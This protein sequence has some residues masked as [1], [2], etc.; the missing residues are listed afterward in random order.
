MRIDPSRLKALLLSLGIGV[1]LMAYPLL[2][3]RM[4]G[5]FAMP[6]L[7]IRIVLALPQILWWIIAGLILSFW[8]LAI[9]GRWG[10]H[11]GPVQKKPAPGGPFY[12]DIRRLRD[13]LAQAGSGK[14]FQDQVRQRLRTLAVNLI[15]L[16][17]GTP[18]EKALE[19]FRE[20]EW[21]HDEVLR[22]YWNLREELHPRRRINH[23]RHWFKPPPP[24]LF[25]Q[26]TEDVLN[27]LQS[28]ISSIDGR[29]QE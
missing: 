16:R 10:E 15:S 28:Y 23:L 22:G 9:W 18:E 11:T 3:D 8:G 1:V 5:L 27:R 24:R 17:Q 7:W 25:L 20:G 26:E 6:A 12:G 14:Y 21:T 29:Q 2:G 19:Q 13:I 4:D